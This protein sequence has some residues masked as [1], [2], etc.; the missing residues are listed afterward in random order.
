MDEPSARQAPGDRLYW[1]TAS[2]GIATLVI[3]VVMAVYLGKQL[4]TIEDRL[5]FQPPEPPAQPQIAIVPEGEAATNTIYVPTYSHIF[6]DGGRALLLETTLSIRNVDTQGSIQI[7]AVEYFDSDG[8]LIESYLSD[9][10]PLRPLQSTEFLVEKADIAGGAGANFIVR[11]SAREDV[12]PPLI[13]AVMVGGDGSK[14]VSF[15]RL[16]QPIAAPPR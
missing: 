3:V 10:F 9:A 2:F 8:V 15:V 14:T 11:W 12:N 13:E 1:L 6:A 16:G 7:D 5:Q 4:E